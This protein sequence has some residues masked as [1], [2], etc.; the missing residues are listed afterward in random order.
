[1]GK[2]E[3][4]KSMHELRNGSNFDDFSNRVNQTASQ[5][6]Y[7]LNI[8]FRVACYLWSVFAQHESLMTLDA[9]RVRVIELLEPKTINCFNRHELEPLCDKTDLPVPRIKSASYCPWKNHRS[10]WH[11]DFN[12]NLGVLARSTM[13]VPK[14]DTAATIMPAINM[15]ARDVRAAELSKVHRFNNL[16]IGTD[17]FDEANRILHL[18]RDEQWK[19]DQEM[20]AVLQRINSELSQ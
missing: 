17:Q 11:P 14:L 3:I 6:P 8:S 1:M 5:H 9:I 10:C 7:F 12:G 15:I 16:P 4:W 19:N 20:V 2:A 13:L 18:I